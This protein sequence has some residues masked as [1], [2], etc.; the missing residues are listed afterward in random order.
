MKCWWCTERQWQVWQTNISHSNYSQFRNSRSQGT[1]RC[2]RV[3]EFES[4]RCLCSLAHWRQR[5]RIFYCL[6]YISLFFLVLNYIS[7]FT[8]IYFLTF[9]PLQIR[10]WN[11]WHDIN[12][13]SYQS[14]IHN[15][16]CKLHI[17]FNN[18]NKV[19]QCE[20]WTVWTLTTKAESSNWEAHM[21]ISAI[22]YHY[23]VNENSDT[24]WAPGE[25]H[26][27]LSWDQLVQDGCQEISRDFSQKDACPCYPERRK[28]NVSLYNELWSQ[29]PLI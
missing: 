22:A 25:G 2:R 6:Q 15:N 17:V 16:K 14:V 7:S 3:F 19:R 18:N 24:S 26:R 23:S 1:R 21:A 8:K 5:E 10:Q 13:E 29:R 28:G 9:P 12:S 11:I 20:A 4:N 27:G